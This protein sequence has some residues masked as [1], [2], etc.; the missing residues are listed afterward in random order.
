MLH[1]SSIIA[2]LSITVHRT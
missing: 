1:I 2:N